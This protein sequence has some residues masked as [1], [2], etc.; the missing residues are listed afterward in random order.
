MSSDPGL[1]AG[2]VWAASSIEL[3]KWSASLVT[4][5]TRSHV[6]IHDLDWSGVRCPTLDELAHA[7]LLK[8]RDL[9]THVRVTGMNAPPPGYVFVGKRRLP[10]LNRDSKITTTTW[11]VGQQL[12]RREFEAGRIDAFFSEWDGTTSVEVADKVRTV[13]FVGS[14]LDFRDLANVFPNAKDVRS[15][16]SSVQ[17]QNTDWAE[18]LG[19]RSLWA[20]VTPDSDLAALARGSVPLEELSLS[21]LTKEAWSV[22]SA[23]WSNRRGVYCDLRVAKSASVN[24]SSDQNVYLLSW[25]GSDVVPDAVRIAAVDILRLFAKT[26][27]TDGDYR[28][29]LKLAVHELNSLDGQFDFIESTER[30]DLVD[31]LLDILNASSIDFAEDVALNLIDS[32]KTW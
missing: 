15:A 25:I 7:P 11:R 22:L 13:H 16:G 29:G 20:T 3:G 18:Y 32:T 23:E 24:R 17:L 9:H 30:D 5:V 8:V 6:S 2:Q 31:E 12:A 19:L 27:E 21:G 10:L 4:H 14:R 28:N 1:A 26:L